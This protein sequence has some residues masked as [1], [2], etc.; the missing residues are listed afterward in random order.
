MSNSNERSL[1]ETVLASLEQFKKSKYGKMFL[2]L[3]TGG[4][5]GILPFLTGM[6]PAAPLLAKI[7]NNSIPFTWT[8]LEPEGYLTEDLVNQM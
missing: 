7:Y 8:S 3:A 5:L 4:G 6:V 1:P 2:A